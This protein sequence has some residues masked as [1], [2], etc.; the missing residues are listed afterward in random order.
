MVDQV[1]QLVHQSHNEVVELTAKGAVGFA[2][3][4]A[5]M[6]INDIAGLIVAFLTGVYMCFQIE[7]AWRNRQATKAVQK[8][9]VEE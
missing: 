4:F 7:S 6:S 1:K 9:I 8:K 3:S 2:G 5:S